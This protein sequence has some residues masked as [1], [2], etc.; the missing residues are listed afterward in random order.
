LVLGS[1]GA[2]YG[3]TWNGG[4]T[5]QGTVFQIYPPQTPDLLGALVTGN[6][7]QVRYSGINGYSYQ[8][9]RSTNLVDWAALGTRLMPSSGVDTNVDLAPPAR[10]AFYRAAWVP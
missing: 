7:A 2:F 10:G 5:N 1:D 8:V 6:T 4:Q 9:L 3:T